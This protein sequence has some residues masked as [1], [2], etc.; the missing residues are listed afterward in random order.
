MKK[1]DTILDKIVALKKKRLE[2]RKAE[3][4]LVELEAEIAARSFKSISFFEVLKAEGPKVKVIAEVKQT[5]PSGGKLRTDFLLADINNAYQNA[6]NVVA[7]SV[8][9]EADH[10]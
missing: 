7:I 10:F 9:T 3:K 8:I 1:T 6:P 2:Q 4:P 5:S